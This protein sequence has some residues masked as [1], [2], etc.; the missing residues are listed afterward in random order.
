M[1]FG[2]PLEFPC[3][4]DSNEYP[5]YSDKLQTSFTVDLLSKTFEVSCKVDHI[6]STEQEL[7]CLLSTGKLISK[8][9]LELNSFNSNTDIC[10]KIYMYSLSSNDTFFLW[11]NP[12]SHGQHYYECVHLF[13][14]HFL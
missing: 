6:M 5:I 11:R 8:S 10:R 1:C 14:G 13:S 3:E 7:Y 9:V 12:Y 2:L 4:G